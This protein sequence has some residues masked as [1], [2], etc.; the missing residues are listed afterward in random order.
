ML[1]WQ[2]EVTYAYILL[3][4]P[5][6]KRIRLGTHPQRTINRLLGKDFSKLVRLAESA[7]VPLPD[8]PSVLTD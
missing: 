5:V 2:G 7:E 4:V 6:N 8:L 1:L 3:K